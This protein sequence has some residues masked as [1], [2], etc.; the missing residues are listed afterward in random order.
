[1]ASPLEKALRLKAP[2]VYLST[3]Q[4]AFWDRCPL[5]QTPQWSHAPPLAQTPEPDEEGRPRALT[6]ASIRERIEACVLA[7]SPL[8]H[9]RDEL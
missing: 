1:M 2:A 8:G 9:D 6:V 5:L 3:D 4:G 7:G